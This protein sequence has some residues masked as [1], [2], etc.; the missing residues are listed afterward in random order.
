MFKNL[1]LDFVLGIKS[2]VFGVW[3]FGFWKFRFGILFWDLMFGILEC[4]FLS[5]GFWVWDLEFRVWYF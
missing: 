1:G 4:G 2:L 3:N 5:F